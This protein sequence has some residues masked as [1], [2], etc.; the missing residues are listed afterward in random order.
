MST[1]TPDIVTNPFAADPFYALGVADAYDEYK[2][3]EDIHNLYRRADEMLDAAPTDASPANFYVCG[4]ANTV[5]GL[6]NTHIAQ[7]NAQAEVAQTWLARK[8]GRET[9]TLHLRHARQARKDTA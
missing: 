7:I 4:Y 5:R 8:Q 6:L 3:G 2:A 9:S 1:A